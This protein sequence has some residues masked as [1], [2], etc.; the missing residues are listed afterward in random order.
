[1]TL[2]EVSKENKEKFLKVYKDKGCNISVASESININRATYYLWR[3]TDSEFNRKCQEAEE[4]LMDYAETKLIK[5]IQDGKE[6]SLIF[7]LKTKG[8]KRGYVEKTE[9]EHTGNVFINL[10]QKY[11]KYIANGEGT[12]INQTDSNQS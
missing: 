3:R 10:L 12:A 8:K 6:A 9:V 4:S 5:N 2:T 1:M 11:D 7:Y